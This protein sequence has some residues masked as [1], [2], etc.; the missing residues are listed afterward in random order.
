MAKHKLIE[1]NIKKIISL[2]NEIT[3]SLKT[4]LEKAILIGQLL[5][6]QKKELKQ[7]CSYE[8]SNVEAEN[9]AN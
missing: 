4:S 6:E 1:A 8:I 7:R 5:I 2:H 9:E 3:E